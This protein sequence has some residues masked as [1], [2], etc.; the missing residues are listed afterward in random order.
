MGFVLRIEYKTNFQHTCNLN[1]IAHLVIYSFTR[2]WVRF[3]TLACWRVVNVYIFNKNSFTNIN[4]CCPFPRPTYSFKRWLALSQPNDHLQFRTSTS[5][6][7]YNSEIYMKLQ[8][9][10]FLYHLLQKIFL[11]EFKL[12]KNLKLYTIYGL[13]LH[14]YWTYIIYP[15]LYSK[16]N[17]QLTPR[18]FI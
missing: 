14:V 15:V 7:W 6:A 4:H 12:K 11:N 13:I 10:N 18:T 16:K 9:I 8:Y 3:C 1:Y 5:P 17:S 2:K